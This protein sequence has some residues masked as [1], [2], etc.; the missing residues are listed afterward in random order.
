MT[1]ESMIRSEV[2]RVRSEV[3]GAATVGTW[4]WSFRDGLAEWSDEMFAILGVERSA[5]RV[6]PF[7]ILRRVVHPEDLPLVEATASSPVREPIEHRVL[8]PDGSVRWVRVEAAQLVLDTEGRALELRGFLRDITRQRREAEELRRAEERLRLALEA[9][10]VGTY[11][12]DMASEL[13][14][15]SRGHEELWGFRPGEFDGTLTAFASR[16][17]PEDRQGVEAEIE[18]VLAARTSYSRE[19]RVLWPDGS[20]H[21]VHGRGEFLH[22]PD[23]RPRRMLGVVVETTERKRAEDA[24]RRSEAQLRGVIDA[25]PV[26]LALVQQERIVSLN[27]AFVRTFGFELAELSR[28][29]D[30]WRCVSRDASVPCSA[31][32]WEA[33]FA[34]FRGEAGAFRPMR[35]GF[36]TKSGATRIVRMEAAAL[37][38]GI[39]GSHLVALYDVTELTR[40]EEAARRRELQLDSIF[41]TVADVLFLVEVRPGEDFRLLALNAAFAAA[42]GLQADQV[43]GQNLRDVLDPPAWAIAQQRFREAI[44]RRAPV[45]WEQTFDLPRGPRTGEVSLSAVLDD[46]GRCTHLVGSVHDVTE[47]KQAEEARLSAERQVQHAQKLESLG[48]LAGGIAHDFNNLLTGILGYS[49]LA[50][51]EAAPGSSVQEHLLE[52]TRCARQAAGLAQQMLAYSGKGRFLVQPLDLSATIE[53]MARLLEIS[54]SKKCVLSFRLARGLP[55]I[56]ADGSQL[57]QVILNLVLNASEAMADGS[58]VIAVRTGVVECDGAPLVDAALQGAAPSGLHVFLEVE[59]DGCGMAPE[60]R[61]RIFDPFFSTKFT[62]RGLGLAAVL[63]IVRGHKGAIQVHSQPG[64]GTLFRILFPAAPQL[65]PVAAVGLRASSWRTSGLALV[66]D[67]EASVRGLARTLL[68]RMGFRVLSACDGQEAVELFRREAANVRLVLLDKTMPRLGGEEAFREMLAI[69]PDVQALLTS[70]YDED[71][72]TSSFTGQGPA[73]FVQKPYTYESL[74]EAIRRVLEPA[75]S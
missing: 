13:I 25:C 37:E 61:A 51:S 45:H 26:P 33:S 20:V 59:D 38:G 39:S 56:E 40:A 6:A 49:D 69:R 63:G 31:S 23:G 10:Q 41:Q 68:E 70:G 18:R 58:G 62:G 75:G 3:P 67:D 42:T 60:T 21:W 14:T 15:W 48:V 24:L 11:D 22:G 46:A 64:D 16:I 1:Q 36:R 50:H 9:T 12:W 35:V 34:R 72:A 53:D 73:G 17:H 30:L 52:V 8:W 32:D 66:V 7:E 19:Y 27:P 4:V 47:R 74:L 54:I 71:S 55:A 65:A 5:Q 43:L 29:E 44:E 2:L 57:R 28:L